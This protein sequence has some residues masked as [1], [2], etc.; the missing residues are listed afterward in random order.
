MGIKIPLSVQE[1]IE[2]KKRKKKKEKNAN[3]ESNGKVQWRKYYE[4]TFSKNEI[5]R[6]EILF[7]NFARLNPRD[8]IISSIIFVKCYN[9]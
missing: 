7:W 5:N 2:K 8:I 4:Y 9:I 6:G 3:E 1:I